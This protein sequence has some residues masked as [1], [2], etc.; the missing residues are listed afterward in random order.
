MEWSDLVMMI[1]EGISDNPND[2]LKR[3]KASRKDR[4]Y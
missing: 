1:I 2:R 4:F 3:L